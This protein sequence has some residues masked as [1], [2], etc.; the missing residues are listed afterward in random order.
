[1]EANIGPRVEKVT[2]WIRIGDGVISGPPTAL[3]IAR[4]KMGLKGYISDGLLFRV[5]ELS[6]DSKLSY[7]FQ[8]QFI[9]DF[10]RVL[11]P[12]QRAMMIGPLA[13]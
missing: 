3:N 13:I 6:D 5:S 9:N 12:E 8:D 1:M 2:Y 10:L 7:Q 11:G 4:L